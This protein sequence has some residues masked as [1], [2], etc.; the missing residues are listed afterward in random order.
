MSCRFHTRIS[1]ILLLHIFYA[2]AAWQNNITRAERYAK[3]INSKLGN[4]SQLNDSTKRI[5]ISK[6]N[7]NYELQIP[8]NSY[9][10]GYYNKVNL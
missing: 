9:E 3:D 7:V 1:E 10:P 8:W 2:L 6:Y 5:H 4:L